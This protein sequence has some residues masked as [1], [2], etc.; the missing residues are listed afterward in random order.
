MSDNKQAHFYQHRNQRCTV[1]IISQRGTFVMVR[2]TSVEEQKVLTVPK[3]QQPTTPVNVSITGRPN[4]TASAS[5]ASL[6]VDRPTWPALSSMKTKV[7]NS[8]LTTTN[9]FIALINDTTNGAI[10][11][12]VTILVKT[13]VDTIP[14]TILW[15]KSTADTNTN[16]A[17]GTYC[18]YQYQYFCDNTFHCL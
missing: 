16:T 4:N 9:S 18:R 2:T 14:I 10:S 6:A 13:I 1:N 7:C 17:V 11:T 5:I 15:Q 12:D 8:T 3:I